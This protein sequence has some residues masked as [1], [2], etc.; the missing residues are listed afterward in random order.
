[1]SA[2][3]TCQ[4]LRAG[5]RRTAT[6]NAVSDFTKIAGH[7]L[8]KGLS[9]PPFHVLS[10]ENDDVG[11]STEPLWHFPFGTQ[12]PFG[13]QAP[14]LAQR[15]GLCT[16]VMHIAL[17][18]SALRKIY[19]YDSPMTVLC[20]RA[21]RKRFLLP[22]FFS[23]YES[24]VPDLRITHQSAS[25]ESNVHNDSMMQATKRTMTQLFLYGKTKTL[26]K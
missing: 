1:M 6:T 14:L 20:V 16:C 17:L 5:K 12:K 4:A 21:M 26:P 8:L 2:S 22:D 23:A 11:P 18:L 24:S 10:A 3:G 13:A 7:I 9:G 25:R 15:Q 19:P